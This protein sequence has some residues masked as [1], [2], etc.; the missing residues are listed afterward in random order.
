MGR[1]ISING[2]TFGKS[3]GSANQQRFND[4]HCK[5]GANTTQEAIDLLCDMIRNV[6]DGNIND[7]IEKQL[8]DIISDETGDWVATNDDIDDIFKNNT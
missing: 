2:R 6:G 3:P 8:G 7:T 5:L 4:S 1:F